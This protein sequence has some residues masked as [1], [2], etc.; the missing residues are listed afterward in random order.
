M[1]S[2]RWRIYSY[3]AQEASKGF[4]GVSNVNWGVPRNCEAFGDKKDGVHVLVCHETEIV[5][6]LKD[7]L[8]RSS[9]Q[10][11]LW[12]LVEEKMMMM[13]MMQLG[14]SEQAGVPLS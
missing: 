2:G 14:E 11:A 6:H 4:T 1:T 7:P 5:T 9:L 13:M 10:K 8:D 3:E 12:V